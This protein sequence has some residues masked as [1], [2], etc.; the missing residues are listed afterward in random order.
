MEVPLCDRHLGRSAK[1]CSCFWIMVLGSIIWHCN[2][3]LKISTSKNRTPITSHGRDQWTGV[4]TSDTWTSWFVVTSI[5][6]VFHTFLN[7]FLNK[8]EQRLM[9]DVKTCRLAL[10][11]LRNRLPNAVVDVPSLE[12]LKV[13]LGGALSKKNWESKLLSMRQQLKFCQSDS[14]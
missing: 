4:P 10:S 12:T 11:Y 6:Q 13:T 1:A 8:H 9:N 14:N 2:L 3:I 7:T 5:P